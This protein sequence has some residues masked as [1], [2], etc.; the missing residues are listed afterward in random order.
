MAVN[1][2]EVLNHD[3]SPPPTTPNSEVTF[4]YPPPCH[5]NDSDPKAHLRSTHPPRPG[6][7]SP[8]LAAPE[9]I[10]PSPPD[11]SRSPRYP[12]IPNSPPL[13]SQAK[14]PVLSWSPLLPSIPNSPPGLTQVRLPDDDAVLHIDESDDI[15]LE[16]AP[17]LNS[18]H[19]PSPLLHHQRSHEL[20]TLPNDSLEDERISA[21][22]L[23]CDLNT[24]EAGVPSCDAGS[25]VFE[26]AG[27]H[28]SSAPTLLCSM[29]R[30]VCQ[31][32]RQFCNVPRLPWLIPSDWGV[33]ELPP[34]EASTSG[35]CG[36]EASSNPTSVFC[37]AEQDPSASKATVP[38]TR[39]GLQDICGVD[40]EL[41]FP[42]L[43]DT[44]ERGNTDRLTRKESSIG[45]LKDV[46]VDDD[47]ET[48][49]RRWDSF[50][51][52]IC[53]PQ[54][55][56]Q[57]SN[58]VISPSEC[59]G[60]R[61]DT[62]SHRSTVLPAETVDF[63]ACATPD[64]M[65]LVPA[66]LYQ[67][68]YLGWPK[69]QVDYRES[70]WPILGTPLLG[71]KVPDPDNFSLWLKNLGLDRSHNEHYPVPS[72]EESVESLGLAD[73]FDED[74]PDARLPIDG[75]FPDHLSSL[76]LTS[77]HSSEVEN[78]VSGY[79]SIT[80]IEHEDAAL[81]EDDWADFEWDNEPEWTKGRH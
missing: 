79:E 8:Q 61:L 65:A 20:F 12:S 13:T 42:T 25:L 32:A 37:N 21:F 80:E 72:I 30:S 5:L 26:E 75:P 6:R 47:P 60:A 33:A 58:W 56:Y 81:S 14:S 68:Q 34:S 74:A 35:L 73:V 39:T 52:T 17:N 36:F 48:T 53:R 69:W 16:L 24:V 55:S 44:L 50:E 9:V 38:N 19:I 28:D 23:T 51:A 40:C 64:C 78:S 59:L 22:L 46:F 66:R 10:V 3:L 63:A 71:A 45:F 7:H 41:I 4:T 70:R 77:V 62:R 1:P 29:E 54:D 43:P 76:E 15:P 31:I 57:L 2:Y 11:R 67:Y 49:E 18:V 27:K